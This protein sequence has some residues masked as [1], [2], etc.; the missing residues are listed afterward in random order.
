[1]TMSCTN[2]NW[3]HGR[4]RG[5]EALSVNDAKRNVNINRELNTKKKLTGQVDF[6]ESIHRRNN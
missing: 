1:M 2:R 4:V 3:S 6:K 5:T